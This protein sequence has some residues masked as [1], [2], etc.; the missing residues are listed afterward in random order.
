[1]MLGVLDLCNSNNA[2]GGGGD[3]DVVVKQADR[4]ESKPKPTD[5]ERV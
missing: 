1:M 3:G 4:P 2:A 5:A